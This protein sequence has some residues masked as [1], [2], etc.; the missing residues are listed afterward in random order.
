MKI[1]E[2]AANIYDVASTAYTTYLQISRCEHL[3]EVCKRTKNTV[4]MSHLN[5][6]R[7]EILIKDLDQATQDYRTWKDTFVPKHTKQNWTEYWNGMKEAFQ[8]LS[9]K[10]TSW[11]ECA[12]K[13]VAF[14]EQIAHTSYLSY[15]EIYM[16]E[17]LRKANSFLIEKLTFHAVKQT[18]IKSSECHL[19]QN[20]RKRKVCRQKCHH[21]IQKLKQ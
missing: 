8:K 3:D 11:K 5:D 7:K 14:L 4:L 10:K 13:Y 15:Y 17:A 6:Q 19:K 16:Q 20:A 1:D 12:Q 21:Q 9:C 2:C 18:C